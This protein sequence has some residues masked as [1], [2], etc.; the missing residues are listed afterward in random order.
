[1]K[2][3]CFMV[4]WGVLAMTGCGQPMQKVHPMKDWQVGV[5]A[6]SFNKFTFY[7]AVDKAAAAGATYIEAFPGQPL[8]KDL[9]GINLHHTM[10]VEN[11]QK[12]QQK[13]AAAGIKVLQYGVVGLPNDETECRQ[14]FAFAKEMGIETIVSEPPAEA[15]EMIDRLCQEYKIKMAIHN[16]PKPSYYWDPQTVLKACAGRSPWIGACADTG[17]WMRSGVRPLDAVRQLKGRIICFHLKDL[18]EFGVPEAHDVVWGTGQLN[19]KELMGELY[20]QGFKGNFSAEYEYHWENSLPEIQQSISN[21]K[22]TA[23]TIK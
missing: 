7:E 6:W 22:A 5:Q 8:S 10:T 4:L 2:T 11:R 3:A 9:P 19:L 23:A 21:F 1:M 14:V 16:H 15:F 20:Q 13:L 18:N 12:A 17:H